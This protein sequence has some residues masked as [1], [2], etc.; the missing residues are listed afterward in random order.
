MRWYDSATFWTAASV[1]VAFVTLLVIYR[2]AAPRRS[3][4]YG[5]P[6]VTPLLSDA[7]AD[8][9]VLHEDKPLILDVNAHIMSIIESSSSPGSLS[10]PRLS[11]D[12]SA[13]AVGPDLIARGQRLTFILLLDGEDIRLSCRS[14][15]ADVRLW[16]QGV[17]NLNFMLR[18]KV[19]LFTVT[20]IQILGIITGYFAL[21]RNAT[22]TFALINF[23]TFGPEAILLAL[24][25]RA[26]FVARRE[27][28]A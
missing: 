2:V 15:I 8:I 11:A 10:V 5:M 26:L 19:I 6:V 16:R 27:S 24:M 22:V 18:T 1:V 28:R 9:K 13:L 20:I 25:I 12:G 14:H 21:A 3:L 17:V 23:I 4:G 7:R